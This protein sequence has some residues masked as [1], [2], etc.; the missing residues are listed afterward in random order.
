MLRVALTGGIGTGKS[1]VLARWRERG[2]PAIEADAVAHQVMA[3]GS[4][5]AAA[6]AARF[7]ADVL[8]AAGEVDRRR[9][10]SIVFSDPGAR[11]DLEGILHPVVYEVI[12]HWLAAQAAQGAALAVAEIPL[13]FETGHSGNFDRVVVTACD[14]PAQMARTVARGS[15]E[16]EAR[17]R[18]AAQWPLADKVRAAHVVIR[19]DGSV[20]ETRARADAAL[21][22]LRAG[23]P[24]PI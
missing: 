22:A 3:A 17:Q 5:A 12:D 1:T 8:T 7:G 21:V 6:I 16:V 14:E 18:I 2:V 19:T 11:R 10:A 24:T 9:L 20:A 4:P 23:A 13:L 15:T